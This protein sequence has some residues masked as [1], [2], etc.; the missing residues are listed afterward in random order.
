MPGR[1]DAISGLS[2][3]GAG[4]TKNKLPKPSDIR[5]TRGL[6]RGVQS[7]RCQLHFFLLCGRVPIST[8]TQS[9]LIVQSTPFFCHGRW[10]RR[11]R[12]RKQ[13][14]CLPTVIERRHPKEKKKCTPMGV[15]NASRGHLSLSLIISLDRITSLV[16][17]R[18]RRAQ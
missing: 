6:K 11:L 18:H 4:L 1:H 8:Y 5:S 17:Y 12:G 7:S 3:I 14:E 16:F 9:I 15:K 13:S 10:Q 2:D